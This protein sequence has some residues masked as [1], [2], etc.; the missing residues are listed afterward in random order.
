MLPCSIK[1]AGKKRKCRIIYFKR[2]SWS[3]V[4][5]GVERNECDL[6]R[7][8]FLA[9]PRLK[10]LSAAVPNKT[11]PDQYAYI[12]GPARLKL[13]IEV[14]ALRTHLV[15]VKVGNSML[16]RYSTASTSVRNVW[17]HPGYGV[18]VSW[19]S[20]LGNAVEAPLQLGRC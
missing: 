8:A 10:K 4:P 18:Y 5:A 15:D 7:S 19:V 13:N 20:L 12:I 11:R 1:V 17:L 16:Q 3:G 6:V 14:V 2:T 9:Q